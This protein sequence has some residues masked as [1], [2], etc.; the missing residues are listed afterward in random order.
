MFN[1]FRHHPD[2]VEVTS[3]SRF[4]RETSSAD[5]KKIYAKVISKASEEQ[6]ALMESSAA[7]ARDRAAKQ[8]AERNTAA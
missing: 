1:L 2:L 7:I 3:L 5:K 4:V 6:K 8:K